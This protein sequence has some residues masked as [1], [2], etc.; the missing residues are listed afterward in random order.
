MNAEKRADTAILQANNEK[1]EVI[2]R[3]SEYDKLIA[4]QKKVVKEKAEQM[5]EQYRNRCQFIWLV[6]LLYNVLATIFT[7]YQ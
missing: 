4:N 7:G 2:K 6:V 5:N 1:E 3:K